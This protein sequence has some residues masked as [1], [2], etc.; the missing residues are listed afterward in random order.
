MTGAPAGR[1]S[2]HAPLAWAW[3]AAAPSVAPTPAGS[4]SPTCDSERLHH[5]AANQHARA[6]AGFQ[7]N[8]CLHR[9]LGAQ[10]GAGADDK[11]GE[12][13]GA[14]AALPRTVDGKRGFAGY[15]QAGQ[16]AALRDLAAK[17]GM[18]QGL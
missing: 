13:L 7:R 3:Q 11:G 8:V 12:V 1:W 10:Q 17:E 5:A 9:A 6:A 4:L 16:L 15:V 18:R 2:K 14:K